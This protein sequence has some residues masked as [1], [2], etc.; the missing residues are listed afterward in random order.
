MS[1]YNQGTGHTETKQIFNHWD[2]HSWLSEKS[3]LFEILTQYSTN[4]LK[5]NVFDY[6]PVTFFVEGYSLNAAPHANKAMTQFINSFYALEDIKKRTARFFE[7]K[8]KKPSSTEVN[9]I[10]ATDNDNQERGESV[11]PAELYSQLADSFIFKYFYS[12]KRSLIIQHKKEA[13]E[14]QQAH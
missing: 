13:R 1:A 7:Q 9:N 3:R 5:E 14:E 12:N 10:Q 2:Q 6:L 4:K 8:D 11:Q